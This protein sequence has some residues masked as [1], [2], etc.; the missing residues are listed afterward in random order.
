MSNLA[1]ASATELAAAIQ[2]REISAVELLKLFLAR[3]D[4][5]NGALNAIVVDIR[6]QALEEAQ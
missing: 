2:K 4:E 5:Y 3:V 6:D 1:F